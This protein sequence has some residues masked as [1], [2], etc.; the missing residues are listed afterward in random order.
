LRFDCNPSSVHC[1]HHQ[2]P[3]RS[4]VSWEGDSCYRHHH[5]SIID[6]T[7]IFTADQERLRAVVVRRCWFVHSPLL[8]IAAVSLTSSSSSLLE[9]QGRRSV[10]HSPGASDVARWHPH[11]L[12]TW[13][14]RSV[15]GC[16]AVAS[17]FHR[18]RL[19]SSTSSATRLEIVYPCLISLQCWDREKACVDQSIQ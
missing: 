12:C 6:V 9:H 11:R 15:V 17:S 18:H 10:I 8:G 13:S 14:S 5:L 4:S 1:H 2:H 16:C 7:G 19:S 3:H